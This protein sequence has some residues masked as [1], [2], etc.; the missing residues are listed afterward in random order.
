MKKQIRV[1]FLDLLVVCLI[2][3]QAEA[4]EKIVKLPSPKY[5]SDTS[6]EEAIF[7][8]RSIRRYKDEALGLQ[9]VSQLLWAAGGKTIDGVTGATRAYPSAG[10]IYPLEI[11]LVVG[12]VKGVSPGAYHYSWHDHTL[13]LRKEGDLRQELTAASLNQRMVLEAPVSLV[14]AAVYSRTTLRYGKRGELRYVPMDVGG[15]GQNVHLQ[16]ESLGLGTV[17][18]GAFSDRAVK[19]VLELKDEEPLYL[20]PVGRPR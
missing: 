8:R 1:K 6:A 10:G 4:A 11:Y 18:I 20:M 19:K 5:K 15:A 7:K 2:L 3:S 17:I 14:F 9:E 16:A 12:N 13:S